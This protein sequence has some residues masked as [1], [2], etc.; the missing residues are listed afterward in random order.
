[1][2]DGLEYFIQET[3]EIFGVGAEKLAVK[4]SGEEILAP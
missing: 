4:K 3:C 1:M 2:E